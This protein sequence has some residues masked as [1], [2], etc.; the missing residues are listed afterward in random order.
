V[1]LSVLAIAACLAGCGGGKDY[2]S[3]KATMQTYFAAAKKGDVDAA[4]A[5][6]CEKVQKDWKEMKAKMEEQKKKLAEKAKDDPNAKKMLEQMEKNDP[7]QEMT[8]EAK[9]LKPEY[10][11]QK[12]DGDKA[13]LKVTAKGETQTINFVKEK[14]AWKI[15]EMV[16]EEVEMDEETTDKLKEKLGEIFDEMKEKDKEQD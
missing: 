9:D 7:S 10:G 11:E 8:K 3:P 13:T 12:I 4:M 16:R 2:S 6:F 5:C 15:A 14:G 1:V